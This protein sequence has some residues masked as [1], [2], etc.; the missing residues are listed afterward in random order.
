MNKKIKRVKLF[1]N[2]NNKSQK[3]AKILQKKLKEKDYILDDEDYELAIAIGGDGSFLR[4]VKDCNFNSQ[5]YYIGINVGTLGFAQEIYPENIDLFLQKLKMNNYKIEDIGIEETK[6][7]TRNKEDKIYS[8]NEILIREKN[9]NTAYLKVLIDENILEKFVGDGLLISTSFGSTAY[10]LSFGGSIIYNELHTLQI[11]PIA[12]L[13]SKSYQVLRNSVI[14]P[15][16]RKIKLIPT[17]RSKDF[18]I[19]I[20]G[21][22]KTYNNIEEIEI[23]VNK[24]IKCLRMNEYDYTKKI[25]EKLL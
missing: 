10:N 15:E 16:K 20:D 5:V 7:K 12:P 23:R 4:M 25:N 8:L 22:N 3:I 14:I 11:T 18:I 21:V 1:P 2:N 24:K 17:S 6:I 19:T 9:L 13:N